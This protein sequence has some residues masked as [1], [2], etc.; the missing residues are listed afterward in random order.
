MTRPRYFAFYPADFAGD[1]NVEA[2]TTLQV[3]AYILL[4]C[5][6]WQADPPA[7]LPN[8]DAVLARLARLTPAEWSEAKAGV[9]SPF[10]LGTDDRWHQ[11][12][13]RQEYET[14]RALIRKRAKAGE[15][16]ASVRWQSHGNRMAEPL[17]PQCEGNGI[18]NGIQN[19]KPNPPNPPPGGTTEEPPNG[20]KPRQRN[21]RASADADPLFVRFWQAYPLKVKKIEAAKAFASLGPSEEL[22]GVILA[23]L[24]KQ[25]RSVEWNK[26][27]GRFVPHP[28]S[29]LKARRWEDQP[30]ETAKP[31]PSGPRGWVDLNSTG[32]PWTPPGKE[33]PG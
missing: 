16:G 19:L 5:K 6:A 13:L 21:K 32:D 25:K 31:E 12:R 22:L 18:Q 1:I 7:S 30:P 28:P 26:E 20:K 14:A 4:L 11:K 10:V 3:G 15:V 24:A 23:A 27:D 2:M 29:W 8:D 33:P 17:R 9:L